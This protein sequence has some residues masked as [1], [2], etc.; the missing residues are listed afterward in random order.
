MLESCLHRERLD[1]S[2]ISNDLAA[3]R[4]K[5][6]VEFPCYLNLAISNGGELRPLNCSHFLLHPFVGSIE[7][8]VA[9]RQVPGKRR[10]YRQCWFWYP[11]S[12]FFL[13]L[14]Q[15]MDWTPRVHPCT[16]RGS[17]DVKGSVLNFTPQLNGVQDRKGSCCCPCLRSGV[18]RLMA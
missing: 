13:P 1:R 4:Q 17:F 12:L 18:W 15:I 9:T 3:P 16:I 5:E 10:R 6:V 2:E 14:I 7:P 11:K 8:L